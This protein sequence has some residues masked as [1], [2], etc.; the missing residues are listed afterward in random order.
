MLTTKTWYCSKN[1]NLTVDL[2]PNW[3][4]FLFSKVLG[5]IN[6]CFFFLF[7]FFTQYHF[8]IFFFFHPWL[9]EM[10]LIL[11]GLFPPLTV[12]MHSSIV[13]TSSVQCMLPMLLTVS[14]G[15]YNRVISQAK[16]EDSCH[17]ITERAWQGVQML[18]IE[19]CNFKK[20]ENIYWNDINLWKLLRD[21]GEILAIL[22]CLL[23]FVHSAR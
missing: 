13:C 11:C 10:L 8:Y 17:P 23:K 5:I 15:A 3:V 9:Y 16:Y 2:N 12:Y 6:D 14:R 1:N 22:G 19:S 4:K 20:A 7:Y 21:F 18:F